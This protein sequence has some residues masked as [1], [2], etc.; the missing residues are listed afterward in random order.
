MSASIRIFFYNFI[1]SAIFMLKT[2]L[3]YSLKPQCYI[4][5]FYICVEIN[6][7]TEFYCG[8]F[9]I[10]NFSF[11]TPQIYQLA[12]DTVVLLLEC[13][14]DIGTLLEWVIDRCYT[15]IPR[16]ADACFLALSSIF[17]VK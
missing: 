12:K 9:L 7:A 11:Y 4:G 2:N 5:S 6:L 13:N 15:A 14:P 16:E 17:N 10:S 3:Y 1:H 8:N